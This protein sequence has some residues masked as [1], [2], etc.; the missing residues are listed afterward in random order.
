MDRMEH[1]VGTDDELAAEALE[2][3][4]AMETAGY[5]FPQPFGRVDWIAAGSVIAVMTLWLIA[6]IWM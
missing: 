4:E 3:I 5:A 1:T 6:G 2:R